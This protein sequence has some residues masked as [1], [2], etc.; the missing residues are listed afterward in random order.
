MKRITLFVTLIIAFVFSLTA[1]EQPTNKPIQPKPLTEKE[2]VKAYQSALDDK[3]EAYTV[4]AF[5]EKEPP[6]KEIDN[7]MTLLP[8]GWN[9]EGIGLHRS[10]EPGL[11][12]T[13]YLSIFNMSHYPFYIIVGQ[14]GILLK[15]SSVNKVTDY[16]LKHQDIFRFKG[17]N[18]WDN[19]DAELIVKHLPQSKGLKK[20]S[21]QTI[22]EPYGM[23]LKYDMTNH[24]SKLE[25]EQNIT[26]IATYIFTLTNNIDLVTMDTSNGTF[27]VK[28]ETLQK[29]YDTDLSKITN[30]KDL[31]ELI[32]N[33]LKDN[34]KMST[35]F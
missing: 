5:I 13:D 28:R 25:D 32:D 9:Y 33:H 16:M 24:L 26:T 34:A 22:K 23:N 27:T 7:I 14:N 20:L 6:P 35:L 29:W 30:E 19:T 8:F 4:E 15:T 10:F 3:K 31:K 1:C 18:I 12:K 21:I 17:T 11:K 2:L